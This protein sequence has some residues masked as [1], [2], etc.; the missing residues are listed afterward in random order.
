M[1]AFDVTRAMV[2]QVDVLDELTKLHQPEE[3]AAT[4]GRLCQTAIELL[5]AWGLY[6]LE[7]D[8]EGFEKAENDLRPR[9]YE[10]PDWLLRAPAEVRTQAT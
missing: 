4:V 10:V 2:R 5:T 3:L 1:P 9:G 6:Q 8:P 7:L